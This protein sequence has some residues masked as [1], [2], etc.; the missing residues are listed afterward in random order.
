MPQCALVCPV[1]CLKTSL[2][3]EVRNVHFNMQLKIAWFVL[4]HPPLPGINFHGVQEF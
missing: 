3:V 1:T 4:K 2:A